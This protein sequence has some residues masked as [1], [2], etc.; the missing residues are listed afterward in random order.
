MYNYEGAPEL[1]LIRRARR[2]DVKAFSELYARI[3]KDLYKFAYYMMRQQ[4]DAEDA[5][6]DAVVAAFENIGKLK[7]EGSFRNWMFKILANQCRKRL[8]GR[9]YNEELSEDLVADLT[10]EEEDFARTQDVREAFLSLEAKDRLIVGWSILG[11]YSSDEISE[12]LGM[13]AATVRSRK[14]RALGKLRQILV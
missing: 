9:E 3:Y 10:A 14:S 1:A 6:G 11:G 7:K 12:A 8:C 2:G 4:Q 5:V 13:N